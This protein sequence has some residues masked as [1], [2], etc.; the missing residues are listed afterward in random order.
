M[1]SE[2]FL[3]RARFEVRLISDPHSAYVHFARTCEPLISPQIQSKDRTTNQS[4]DTRELVRGDAV[5]IGSKE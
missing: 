4:R 5:R 3:G 2:F 1:E